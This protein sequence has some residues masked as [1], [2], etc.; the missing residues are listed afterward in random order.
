MN[1]GLIVAA[2]LG[3]RMPGKVRKQYLSL[4][5]RPV[6][7]HSLAAFGACPD[8]GRVILVV[9]AADLAAVARDIVQPLK[10]DIPV[11]LVAGGK[12]RQDSVYNGLEK[13]P[14]GNRVIVVHD[15]VRPFIGP[16]QITACIR[17]AEQNGACILGIPVTETLKQVSP[18][19]Q[20]E[21][22][23]DRRRIWL[24][25][26]PQAFRLALL[27][28]AH[29]RA[30]QQGVMDTDDAALVERL[31]IDVSVLPGRK[32]NIK[33]TVPEDLALAEA[34]LCAFETG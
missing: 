32:E 14:A 4:G 21:A 33:I 30:R 12:E 7:S 5:G 18:S 20:I 22:T 9:P 25:Q 2:G 19:G 11:D 31:G 23:L 8:I 29:E 16:G 17:M 10:L 34:L 13:V 15:G 24:A 1:A 28:Q 26:T 3:T 27:K 6:L